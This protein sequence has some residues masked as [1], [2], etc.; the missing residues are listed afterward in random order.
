MSDSGLYP[1]RVAE[2]QWRVIW[3]P[4]GNPDQ[5]FVGTEAAVRRKAATQA[6]SEWCPII[7]KREIVVGPWESA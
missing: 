7:E 3:F 4:P 6:V 5:T 2:E 1:D